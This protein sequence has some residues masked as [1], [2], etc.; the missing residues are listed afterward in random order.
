M[1]VLTQKEFQTNN[2]KP[3]ELSVSTMS[4]T[5]SLTLTRI[6]YGVPASENSTTSKRILSRLTTSFLLLTNSA[7]SLLST[8][9]LPMANLSSSAI[10]NISL[11]DLT[12]SCSFSNDVPAKH[13]TTLIANSSLHPKLPAGKSSSSLRFLKADSMTFSKTCPRFSLINVH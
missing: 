6:P 12:P 4:T 10:S 9:P 1:I 11:T 13:A 5:A 3:T 7:L 8:L 2:M